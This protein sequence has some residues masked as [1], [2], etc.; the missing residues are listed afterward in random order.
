MFL[1]TDIEMGV[2]E[3]LADEQ[4]LLWLHPSVD[5]ATHSQVLPSSARH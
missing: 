1:M 3:R 4:C 2:V 5:G